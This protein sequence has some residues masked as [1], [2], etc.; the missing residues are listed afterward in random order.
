MQNSS[1]SNNNSS[2]I[3]SSCGCS[4]CVRFQ[5]YLIP[6]CPYPTPSLPH[7]VLTP[8]VHT[9]APRRPPTP[10]GT[11][12]WFRT[13]AARCVAARCLAAA[14]T[15]AACCVIRG[16]VR[17][18]LFSWR[19]LAAT[20]GGRARRAAAA[21]TAFRAAARARARCH[22]ATR[23][24]S[25]ATRARVR[26][27]A[28]AA[29]SRA[30]AGVTRATRRAA[31]AALAAGPRAGGGSGVDAT[32]VSA[33]ATPGRAASARFRRSA[34]ARAGR[35]ATQTWGA[36]TGRR[37]A[38]RRADGRLRVASTLAWS[39]ATTA[40]VPRCVHGNGGGKKPECAH[41]RP[42]LCPAHA[43]HSTCPCATAQAHAPQHRPM[44]TWFLHV[45]HRQDVCHRAAC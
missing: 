11:P 15:P 16:R 2:N 39:G 37:R 43:T 5:T 12:G 30:P 13:A 10:N 35:P 17:R 24:G 28:F 42:R 21:V 41:V 44:R 38:G 3:G 27:A 8:P 19:M 33:C 6:H 29:C 7:T 36:W 4:S 9:H 31:R 14:A 18:A 45:G 20:A 40:R 34:R 23:A 22:A 1:S 25:R 32:P 26:R